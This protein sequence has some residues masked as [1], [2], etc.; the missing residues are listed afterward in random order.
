MEAGADPNAITN[1]A[2]GPLLKP[3]I[4]EYFNATERPQAFI[5][6]KLLKYGAKIVIKVSSIDQNQYF[7]F[8]FDYSKKKCFFFL[9]LGSS[10]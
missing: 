3:P 1:D 4:G 9:S 7:N 10:T 6:R 2:R 5:V 8:H